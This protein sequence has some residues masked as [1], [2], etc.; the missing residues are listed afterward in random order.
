MNEYNRP[1]QARPEDT[2]VS[3]Y[4]AKPLDLIKANVDAKQKGYND[5]ASAAAAVGDDIEWDLV[6]EDTSQLNTD[7]AE[8]KA[9]IANAL[10]QYDGD[11]SKIGG[12]VSSEAKRLKNSTQSVGYKLGLENKKRIETDETNVAKHS[13][14]YDI[15]ELQDRRGRW[16]EAGGSWKGNRYNNIETLGDFDV[17]KVMTDAVNKLKDSGNTDVKTEWSTDGLMKTITTDGWTGILGKTVKDAAERALDRSDKFK[18]LVSRIAKFDKGL[19]LSTEEGQKAYSELYNEVKEDAMKGIDVYAT[20]K[21]VD[22]SV[23]SKTALANALAKKK[24]EDGAARVMTSHQLK[25]TNNTAYTDAF[26]EDGF[27]DPAKKVTKEEFDLAN[28]QTGKGLFNVAAFGKDLASANSKLEGLNNSFGS[29]WSN[30]LGS[31]LKVAKYFS[32]GD[33]SGLNNDQLSSLKGVQFDSAAQRE[34]VSNNMKAY[35]AHNKDMMS[36]EQNI[37]KKATKAGII[38]ERTKDVIN[39]VPALLSSSDP[40]MKQLGSFIKDSLTGSGI[41]HLDPLSLKKEFGEKALNVVLKYFDFNKSGKNPKWELLEDV[42]LP[43][44]S[45][46]SNYQYVSDI[47]SSE[48]FSGYALD[49]KGNI[50]DGMSMSDFHMNSFSDKVEGS[51]AAN[52]NISVGTGTTKHLSP[53]G[54]NWASVQNGSV[55]VNGD[56]QKFSDYQSNEIDKILEEQYDVSRSEANDTQIKGATAV[57]NENMGPAKLF[58]NEND[59]LVLSYNGGAVQ[60]PIGGD[61]VDATDDTG[62]ELLQSLA[63]E[64]L[65]QMLTKAAKSKASK[66]ISGENEL[67]ESGSLGYVRD[68]DKDSKTTSVPLRY[69]DDNGEW[70]DFRPSVVGAVEKH[71]SEARQLLKQNPQG[72][73]KYMSENIGLTR[74]DKEPLN[75]LLD[76]FYEALVNNEKSQLKK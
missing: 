40:E 18:L 71:V 53:G 46:D 17:D 32:S 14:R 35:V 63:P 76:R 66:S 69:R 24:V 34:K 2:Y 10:E 49:S 4:V 59:D 9:R 1:I 11:Y 62:R 65:S 50:N 20:N 6:S 58:V 55:S 29:D 73:E 8:S 5:V 72:F 30:N 13:N 45:K 15:A 21:Y 41:A 25:N 38:T 37:L 52:D 26:S 60:K 33:A 28:T 44:L 23:E 31:M 70:Q 16:G 54:A 39:S 67:S 51:T 7:L 22:K 3:Q 42:E 27:F 61:L 43:E 64:E 68:F 19:D 75:S 12:V 57:F 56:T 36:A 74:K 47:L 48:D